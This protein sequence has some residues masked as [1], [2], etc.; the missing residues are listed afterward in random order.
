MNHWTFVTAA[1]VLTAAGSL[2]V[3]LWSYFDMRRAERA[4]EELENRK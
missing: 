1:Y 2:A 4:V 3:L